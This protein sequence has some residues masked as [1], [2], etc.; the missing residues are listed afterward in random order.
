MSN[1][2]QY[3]GEEWIEI[4]K[5]GLN[6]ENGLPGANGSPD[7]PDQVTDKVNLGKPL[8]KKERVEGLKDIEFN[9][10]HNLYTGISETRALELIK[11]N[12]T[13]ELSTYVSY[14]TIEQF[15]VEM[16]SKLGYDSY[17]EYTLTGTNITQVNYWTDYG[18]TTK[19]F[20]KDITYNGNN[21][22]TVIT[23]KDEIANK[24]LTTTIAYS[25]TTITNITKVIS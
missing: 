21:D 8:I 17:M 14:T 24:T 22:P 5:D 18:K 23:S 6:G 4:A 1:L 12:D 2:Y 20:T 10:K 7:T 13:L 3:N 19:L 9:L 16:G 25:G 15:E 11:N